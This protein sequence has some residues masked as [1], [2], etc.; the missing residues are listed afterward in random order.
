MVEG[1]FIAG[2]VL[3]IAAISIVA[4]IKGKVDV[5]QGGGVVEERTIEGVL[6]KH[7]DRLMSLPGVVGTAQSLCEGKPCI[8]VY[9]VERTPELELKIPDALDGYPVEIEETGD[10]KALPGERD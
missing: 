6:K 10:I 4:C 9:V 8:R 3:V 5:R 2:V 7:T 1:R